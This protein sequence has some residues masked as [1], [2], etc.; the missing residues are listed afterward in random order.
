MWPGSAAAPATMHGR[1]ACMHV[2]HMSSMATCRHTHKRAAF[3]LV[4]TLAARHACPHKLWQVK[5]PPGNSTTDALTQLLACGCSLCPDLLP[6]SQ[7][8]LLGPECC[9]CS[10]VLGRLLQPFDHQVTGCMESWGSWQLAR[11]KKREAPTCIRHKAMLCSCVRCHHAARHLA[12][13]RCLYACAILCGRGMH[14]SVG[15]AAC[16][17]ES[18]VSGATPTH[19]THK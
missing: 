3:C 16:K 11:C 10:Q 18:Q 5:C 12:V 15:V 17:R 4:N 1:I 14:T 7:H 13:S 9:C 2:V 8:S 6:G 19:L